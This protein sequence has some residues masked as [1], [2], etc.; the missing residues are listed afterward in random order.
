[1]D[2]VLETKQGKH[3]TSTTAFEQEIK[4]EKQALKDLEV[5]RVIARVSSLNLQEQHELPKEMDLLDTFYE[6]NYESPS[7]KGA[8]EPSLKI[9][10]REKFSTH[11]II[12]V[13]ILGTDSIQDKLSP[14]TY[15]LVT[16]DLYVSIQIVHNVPLKYYKIC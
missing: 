7:I 8:I 2:W 3:I 14:L 4:L 11:L 15:S 5:T 16:D 12:N 1:M 13:E 10:I 9:T 6:F